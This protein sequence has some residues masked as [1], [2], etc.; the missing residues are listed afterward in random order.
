MSD[1]CVVVTDGAHSRFFTLEPVDFPEVE[2]GP[3]LMDRGEL[4]NPEK[5]MPDRDLY[6]SKAGRYQAP[7]GGP[8]H[9][10]DDHRS[11]HEDEFERRFVREVLKKAQR[12]A[13]ANQSK[14]VVLAAPARTLGFLSQKLDILIKDGVEVQKLGK[15]LIKFYPRQ[16]HDY[17]AREQMLP[18]RKRPGDQTISTIAKERNLKNLGMKKISD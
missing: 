4:F 9:G 11:Q 16:I 1:Y 10:F 17:L 3:N 14:R 12:L 15:D 2:S 6:T 5:E 18:A 7:Q 8:A 13:R